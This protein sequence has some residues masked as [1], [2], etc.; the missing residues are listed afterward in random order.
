MSHTLPSS[1][2]PADEPESRTHP[3]TSAGELEDPARQEDC[4]PLRAWGCTASI[5]G[6]TWR[7]LSSHSTSGG[8]VEYCKCDCDAIVMLCQEEVSALTALPSEGTRRKR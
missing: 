5:D 3:V 8:E 2:I 4:C 7:L 6:P 1:P